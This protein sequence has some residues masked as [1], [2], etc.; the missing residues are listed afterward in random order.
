MGNIKEQLTVEE[1][2]GMLK[3]DRRVV[4]DLIKAGKIKAGKVGR[5]WRIEADS[6]ARFL[7]D[8]QEQSK[9]EEVILDATTFIKTIR[10]EQEASKVI[11]EMENERK[12]GLASKIRPE[13]L[14]VIKSYAKEVREIGIESSNESTGEA[15]MY[16]FYYKKT[17]REAVVVSDNDGLRFNYQIK[18]SRD[19]V[20]S[21]QQIAGLQGLTK[22]I[23]FDN[24]DCSALHKRMQDIIR[25][26]II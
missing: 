19:I 8:A 14:S 3:A 15:V 25:A 13:V 10:L 16:Y 24:W 2:A 21:F 23:S 20:D 18:G 12:I 26:L 1:V 17:R 9:S 5:G 6:V 4:Y 11:S 22:G 7:N